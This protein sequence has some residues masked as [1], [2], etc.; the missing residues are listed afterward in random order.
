[1]KSDTREKD[2]EFALRMLNLPEREKMRISGNGFRKR[3]TGNCSVGC[4]FAGKPGCR[5]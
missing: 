3:L 2:I 4:L 1:M 5:N